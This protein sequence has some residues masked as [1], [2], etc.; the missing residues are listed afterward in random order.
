LPEIVVKDAA[1]EDVE[2]I[3]YVCS[4]R[5]LSD[6]SH[7]PGI[8][9]K[10]KWLQDMMDRYGSMTKL[11][12]LGGRPAALLTYY[13]EYADPCSPA[14]R[15]DY[16]YVHCIYNNGEGTQR[17]GIGTRLVRGLIAEMGGGHPWFQGG[18]CRC[19]V[20]DAFDTFE[21]YPMTKFYEGLGFRRSAEER[22]DFGITMYYE[23]A[24]SYRRPEV[25]DRFMPSRTDLGK[26]VVFFTP[27][28]QF[29]LPFAL[30]TA[31]MVHEV[32]PGYPVE[33]MNRWERP[34]E[35]LRRG[36]N[37]L[38]VNGRPIRSFIGEKERFRA[39]V[40]AAAANVAL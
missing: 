28:C 11:A 24:G 34:Q 14:R 4:W 2:D 6:P 33:L 26:A 30:K 29:S 36:R 13:P 38:V 21:H 25:E 35:Y 20:A 8:D 31:R 23:L 32:L 17:K 39:E 19:I 22:R 10:R 1:H 9:L 5:R 7:R 40:A 15:R 18:R 3:I 27:S 16:C 12:Y 37:W